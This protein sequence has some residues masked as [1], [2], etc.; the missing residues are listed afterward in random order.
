VAVTP[1]LPPD[2]AAA[3][4]APARG[5]AVDV[6][7]LE[8]AANQA[9]AG[10]PC[11]ELSARVGDDRRA[12]VSGVVGLPGDIPRVTQALA[13]VD[14]LGDIDTGAILTEPRPVCSAAA[15][16]GAAARTG[17]IA[18][19]TNH[20]DGVFRDGDYLVVHTAVPPGP[21]LHVYVDYVDPGGDV[22]HL[23][24]NPA[25]PETMV[26]G[27]SEVQLGVEAAEAQGGARYY[28]LGAPY[29]RAAVLVLASAAPLFPSA[30]A[31]V[32]PATTYLPAL[33]QALAAQTGEV[34]G[35]WQYVEIVAGE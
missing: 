33:E 28:Q 5:P 8:R 24:P 16:V 15:L 13:A 22:V 14:G 2:A 20:A 19:S 1:A 25:A 7:A 26:E 31:E 34:Q 21:P 35:G 9:L 17:G 6:A 18:V 29:G 10:L 4:D 30:R 27:G 11:A 23:R 32:E 3:P 12:S